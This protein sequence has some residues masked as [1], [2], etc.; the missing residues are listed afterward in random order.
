MPLHY[1]CPVCGHNRPER[2]LTM[3]GSHR[4]EV[5][6]LKG[7]GYGRGFERIV[8]VPDAAALFFLLDVLDRARTQVATALM[9][10]A[11]ASQLLPAAPMQMAAAP[12]PW[13]ATPPTCP[14]CGWAMGWAPPGRWM[15]PRC[16]TAV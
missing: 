4:L 14:R 6:Q 11:P 9:Q 8:D 2:A 13:P 7:L 10:V 1:R 5:C 12:Q 16:G 3:A 15:C